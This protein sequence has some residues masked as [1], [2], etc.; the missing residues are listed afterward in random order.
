VIPY[1]VAASDYLT[2][3]YGPLFICARSLVLIKK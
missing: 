1:K 2:D 3:D